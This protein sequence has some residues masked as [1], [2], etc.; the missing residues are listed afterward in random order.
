VSKEIDDIFSSIEAENKKLE[1][2]MTKEQEETQKLVE[3][4]TWVD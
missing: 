1:E 3:K 4:L 2:N